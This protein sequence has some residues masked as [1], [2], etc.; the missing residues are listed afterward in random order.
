MH[1]EFIS[2]TL[3]ETDFSFARKLELFCYQIKTSQRGFFALLS[4]CIYVQYVQNIQ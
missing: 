3:V 1:T 2:K 4:I